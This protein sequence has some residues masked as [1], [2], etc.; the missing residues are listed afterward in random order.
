[1]VTGLDFWFKVSRS[2]SKRH[3]IDHWFTYMYSTVKHLVEHLVNEGHPI[4]VLDY[5]QDFYNNTRYCYELKCGPG[6]R[7]LSGHSQRFPSLG[8]EA[9]PR[10]LLLDCVWFKR[11]FTLVSEKRW[12]HNCHACGDTV[13]VVFLFSRTLFPSPCDM[14]SWLLSS[15]VTSLVCAFLLSRFVHNI[16]TLYGITHHC[17]V[18][19]W[20]SW[21]HF[22]PHNTVYESHSRGALVHWCQAMGA[23]VQ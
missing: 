5:L 22:C 4:P 14:F 2:I 6:Q 11:A 12:N 23:L 15:F 1:M 9:Y 19:V 17:S 3:Q 13:V 7:G 20:V 18:V 21:H 8:C 10:D 16:T